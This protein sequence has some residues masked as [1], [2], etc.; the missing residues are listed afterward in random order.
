MKKV[1]L[2]LGILLITLIISLIGVSILSSL[3]L[4]NEFK[5]TG[6]TSQTIDS[7]DKRT[8]QVSG[9]W[10]KYE[11]QGLWTLVTSGASMERGI[12]EGMLTKALIYKQERAFVNQIKKLVPSGFYLNFLKYIISLNN[13]WLHAAI[14]PENREEIYGVSRSASPQFDDISSGYQR[15][16]NY[17]GAHD[18]GHFLTN[19]GMVGC[20]SFGVWGDKTADG[21]LLIGRN[22]DFYVGDEF[23]KEKIVSIIRPDSGYKLAMITWG[24]MTGVVS[25]M[26]EKGLTV[27]INASNSDLSFN[28][29]TPVSIVAR[30][31]LQ[32]A[33]NI[34]EA[35]DVAARYDIFVSELFL[36]GSAADNKAVIIEKRPGVQCI[37]NPPGNSILST[38]H[39]QSACFAYESNSIQQ[40]INTASGPRFQ[41]LRKL[42]DEANP[43]TP[44][45]VVTILRD[46]K[47]LTNND[48]GLGN[49]QSLHQFIGH[50][51]IVLSPT[52]LRF[53]ISTAPYQS[54]EF[55]AYDLKKLFDD[56][57]DNS[58]E[59]SYLIDS[60]NIPGDTLSFHQDI[61][62][63][64]KYRALK[65]NLHSDNFTFQQ[66][67]TLIINNP[68]YFEPYEIKGDFLQK[69]D[70]P[71]EAK[72]MYQKALDCTLPTLSDKERILKKLHKIN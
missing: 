63:I 72:V 60:L 9:D 21:K 22:F 29:A 47:G 49:E 65:R 38:N 62:R 52:E 5:N 32:Y 46:T 19:L 18:L 58:Y 20:S 54:G 4:N 44:A 68:C 40:R 67:D 31:I 14:P 34:E 23:A 59:T 13:Y 53:W 36:I 61:P 17:H 43:F 16:L 66:V 56:Q 7:I 35:I 70:R 10:L 33:S 24:G 3:Y 27:T 57:Y 42:I 11:R 30:Q 39:F 6:L 50:H 2:I 51:S 8:V 15:I 28:I 48:I 64:K 37:F 26:N 12:R 25:G 45:S 69:T 71:D 41:R 1:I 55:V